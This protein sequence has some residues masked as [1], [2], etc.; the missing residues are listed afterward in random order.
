MFWG[1]VGDIGYLDGV[2]SSSGAFWVPDH[3]HSQ[4]C[5]SASLPAGPARGSVMS[6]ARSF[7][8]RAT[9]WSSRPMATGTSAGCEVQRAPRGSNPKVSVH[10]ALAELLLLVLKIEGYRTTTLS[11]PTITASFQRWRAPSSAFPARRVVNLQS[12]LWLQRQETALPAA[13]WT[14]ASGHEKLSCHG[15][16]TLVRNKE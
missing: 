16:S 2:R 5:A 1:Y 15:S 3:A 8:A 4:P 7:P 14:V 10:I 6:S 13:T 9:A 12:S 11:S